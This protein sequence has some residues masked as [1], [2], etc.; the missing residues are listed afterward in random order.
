MLFTVFTGT[1][2]TTNGPGPGGFAIQRSDGLWYIV[3]GAGGVGCFTAATLTEVYNP[4][5]KR[6]VAGTAL[7]VAVSRGAHAIPRPDGSLLIFNGQ[8]GAAGSTATQIYVENGG[9]I[10]VTG[11]TAGAGITFVGP[12]APTAIAS[13]AISFQRDD[14]KFVVITGAA[15]TTVATTVSLYDAGWVSQGYYRSEQFDMN[16]VGTKLASDSSLVWKSNGVRGISAEVR[17]ATTQAALGTTTPREIPTSGGLINPAAT[18]TWMSITFNFKRDFPSYGGINQD[19]WSTNGSGQFRVPYRTVN[20]PVLYEYKVTKDKNVIDLQSD[21]L[22]VFRVSSSGDVFTQAGGTINTS[23]ADLAERY[24]SQTEL[25]KGE[26]VAIDPQN[27]HGVMRSKYQYQPDILGVVST[28]PGFVAGAYTENSYPIALIGRVPVKVSTENGPIRTGDYLTAASIPGYAMKATLSGRVIGKSLETLDASKSSECPAS[29]IYMAN[30]KCGTVMV[31]VN[32]I[33]YNGASVDVAMSDWKAAKKMEV[34]KLAL[35]SGLEVLLSDTGTTT[36][37]VSFGG[38]SL[39]NRDAEVLDFLTKLKEE[40]AQGITSQSELFADKVSAVSQVISPEVIANLVRALSVEGLSVTA[41][42]VTAEKIITSSISSAVGG[43]TMELLPDGRL[44]MRRVTTA[45]PLAVSTISISSLQE[46]TTNSATST[47]FTEVVGVLSTS[48][49]ATINPDVATTTENSVQEVMIPSDIVISF[50]V[51]GNAFFAG[52]LVARKVS[53]GALDVSGPAKFAGGLEVTTLG[54]ASST[55]TVLSDTTFFGRPYFTSDTG[56]T[57]IVTSG[58]R[59]VDIIFD[60]E[61][62][63]TPILTA[64]M[65]FTASTTD[66]NI[67]KIF[68]DDIR[69]VVTKRT[70]TGFTIFLNKKTI[71]EVTFNWLALAVKDSK[72]FT[73]RTVHIEPITLPVS[74]PGVSTQATTTPLIASTTS[75][76]PPLE[77]ATTTLPIATSSP[78][79]LPPPDIAP[80][81]EIIPLPP[82]PVS[83]TLV[84]PDADPSQFPPEQINSTP[85]MQMI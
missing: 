18:D 63:E 38:T 7:G 1:N 61:Y 6:L 22:S 31:F 26:V 59:S 27:N 47:P 12:V 75:S 53:T 5:S 58:A 14:G 33:D 65:T 17:T 45:P 19:V 25:Q 57:A 71:T 8:V 83:D 34:A 48:T 56:G 43:F 37:T 29:D 62:I 85:E 84:L 28:D 49:V 4:V 66:E 35:D 50:D 36:P 11:T 78:A 9:T 39:S 2:F 13:G 80:K 76:L 74:L 68:S 21:G 52:D 73:S 40:R 42:T 3:K 24:T 23:G 44:I 10:L 55:M 77:S 20:T 69:F 32:L 15:T 46:I 79:L 30:Q 72:E 82:V 51:T 60:R 54:I 67:E 41:G 16:P 81:P 70:T 64:T